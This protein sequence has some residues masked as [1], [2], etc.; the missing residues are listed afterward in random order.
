MLENATKFK[1]NQTLGC[2]RWNLQSNYRQ[3][4]QMM[5]SMKPW[6]MLQLSLQKSAK[7]ELLIIQIFF[8]FLKC[9]ENVVLKSDGH[10]KEF[11]EIAIIL[12]AL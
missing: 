9:F 12:T 1:T 5:S 11:L 8:I 3:K 7:M 6:K 2:G 10:L 4:L